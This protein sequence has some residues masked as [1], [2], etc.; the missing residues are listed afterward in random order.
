MKVAF[1]LMEHTLSGSTT[2]LLLLYTLLTSSEPF[3]PYTGCV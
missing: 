2:F 1:E 3:A